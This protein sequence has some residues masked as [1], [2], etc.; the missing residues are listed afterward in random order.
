M[1]KLITDKLIA[2]KFN[3]N[4]VQKIFKILGQDL[5]LYAIN[6]FSFI[7]ED[8]SYYLWFSYLLYD[9]DLTVK[10]TFDNVIYKEINFS[11]NSNILIEMKIQL[12]EV[13][14]QEI[15][16]YIIIEQTKKDLMP[17]KKT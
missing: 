16:N 1:D 10:D 4:L 7:Y 11:V 2:D 9:D 13:Q 6:N 15:R 5:S 12:T 17:N 14:I 3:L 8:H